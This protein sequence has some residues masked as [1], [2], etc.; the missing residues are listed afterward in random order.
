V[1]E[2]LAYGT[3]R[4]VESDPGWPQDAALL[5]RRITLALG[6]IPDRIEHVGSTAVDGLAAKPIIDLAV[7]L[8]PGQDH[9]AV[10]KAFEA[11]GWEFRGDAGSE[12]GLVFVLSPKPLHRVAHVHVVD[13]GDP[14]WT[15]YLAVRDRLRADERARTAYAL[16]KKNLARRF[17]T[18][19]GAYT[20][21][22][23]AFI[24]RLLDDEREAARAGTGR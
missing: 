21:G 18:D 9:D 11:D 5:G 23:T 4:V 6:P 22:K 1:V 13:H 8:P 10:I 2:G 17:P 7:R 15:R 20:T 12:G 14:Q 19:R 24:S 16:L 3:V